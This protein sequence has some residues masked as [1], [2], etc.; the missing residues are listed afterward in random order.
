MSDNCACTPRECPCPDDGKTPRKGWLRRAF[1]ACSCAGGVAGGAA[2]GHIGCIA[3]P[4][5]IASTGFTATAGTASALA[6]G[7]SAVLTGTGIH[8]WNR[9]RRPHA[10]R[11]EKRLTVPGALAGL[12]VIAIMHFT[13]HQRHQ[14]EM[15]EKQRQG[16]VMPSIPIC[17][18]K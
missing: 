6:L 9:F 14:K 5:L 18:G 1:T 16:Y 2:L 12:A 7:T 10:S 4:F 8:M 15:Q 11:W 13:Q 3:T 17:G